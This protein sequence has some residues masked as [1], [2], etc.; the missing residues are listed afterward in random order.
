M[1]NLDHQ[2]HAICDALAGDSG[3]MASQ[4]AMEQSK[5]AGGV[6]RGLYE[7]TTQDMAWKSAR[8][9]SAPNKTVLQECGEY[10]ARLGAKLAIVGAMEQANTHLNWSVACMEA[11]EQ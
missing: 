10:H 3:F 11:N 1:T 2:I 4:E 9:P 6:A 7:T 5:R 8:E